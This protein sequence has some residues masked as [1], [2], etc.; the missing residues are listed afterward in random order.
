MDQDIVVQG[1]H[2]GAQDLEFIRRLIRDHP[3][4]SRRRLSQ[5]LCVQW[6]WRNGAGAIKDMAARALLGKLE[7]RGLIGLP[8]RRCRTVSRMQLGPTLPLVWEPEARLEATLDQLGPLTIREVSRDRAQRARLAAALA[9]YHYLGHRGTVGEN[10]QYTVTDAEERLLA[11]L[12]FGSAAWKCKVRDEW[13][14]WSAERR[15]QRLHWVTNNTRFLILPWVRVAH[16]ASWVL[17]RVLRR[18]SADWQDKYGHPIVLVET[19]VEQERF[20]G[21]CYRA[22]NWIRLGSTT[23]RSRQDRDGTL[24]V[25]VKDVYVYPLRPD[26][27]R[28]LTR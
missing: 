1:R 20:A 14:G 23:G 16:L 25:A 2:L 13:I 11:C 18:L 22:A 5:A 26:F 27:R 15:R 12:L 19:F 17:G 28:E 24:R 3:S 4:W 10:L 7:A 21:T 9:R 6:D 8:P